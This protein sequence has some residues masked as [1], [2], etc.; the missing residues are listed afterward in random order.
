[1]LSVNESFIG[2]APPTKIKVPFLTAKPYVLKEPYEQFI[3]SI[4]ISALSKKLVLEFYQREDYYSYLV[5]SEP[6]L[7]IEHNQHLLSQ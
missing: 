4:C 2:G 3:N 7:W 1:M 5:M 6:K